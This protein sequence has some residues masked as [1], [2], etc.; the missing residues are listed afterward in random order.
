ME[1]WINKHILKITIVVT[2]PLWI[3]FS[4]DTFV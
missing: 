3:A 4:I 2:L 1:E